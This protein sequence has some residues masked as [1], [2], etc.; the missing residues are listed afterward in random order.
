MIW[1]CLQRCC[2]SLGRTSAIDYY[3]LVGDVPQFRVEAMDGTF[4]D[5]FVC[6]SGTRSKH[7]R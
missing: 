4:V 5:Y 6:D 1:M 3:D 7:E 2:P